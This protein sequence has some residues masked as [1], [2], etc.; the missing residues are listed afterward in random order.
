MLGLGGLGGCLLPRPFSYFLA[1]NADTVS[2]LVKAVGKGT[3]A[4]V[5]APLGTR[6]HVLGPLGN[7]LPEIDGEVWAVAGGVGA[8]PFGGFVRT[9]ARVEVLFGARTAAETGFATALRALG[10]KVAI[11]T[12]DGSA[13]FRGTV[14]EMLRSRLA[15]TRPAALVVCGPEPMMQAVAR[16]AIDAALPCFVSLEARMACGIGVCRGCAHKT[17]TGAHRCICVDGPVFAAADIYGTPADALG[18]GEK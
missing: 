3:D 16:I 12:D 13:G 18:G 17:A 10:A 8:A 1:Q 2:L 9:G 5:T 6:F 4:L 7:T 15:Q 14:A 11:A